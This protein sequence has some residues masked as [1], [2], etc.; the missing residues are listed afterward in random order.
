M[1][2]FAKLAVKK[3]EYKTKAICAAAAALTVSALTAANA[4]V[5]EYNSVIFL[6]IIT[7]VVL[8]LIF[9]LVSTSKNCDVKILS[10][11]AIIIAVNSAIISE[12]VVNGILSFIL[13]GLVATTIDH[14]INF[15]TAK[16]TKDELNN[17]N[18]RPRRRK[19]RRHK[20]TRNDY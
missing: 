15:L 17:P 6:P 3:N 10:V 4:N 11:A 2:N 20:K 8:G 9:H 18:H 14:L 1:L 16:N 5:Y 12:S 13:E 19:N 7:G